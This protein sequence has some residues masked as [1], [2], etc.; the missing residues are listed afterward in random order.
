MHA[1]P[2]S[3][4]QSIVAWQA[5]HGRHDLPW[6]GTRDPYRIWLSEIMLQQTQVAAVI[7]YYQRFL[8]R[9]PSVAHLA[10]GTQE[11][12]LALWSGLGYYTRAR[13]LHACAIQVLEN[14]NGQFP[15]DPA[16]LETLPGIGRSTAAAIAAF[17][18]DHSSPIL[19]G[20]VKRVFCRVFAI[21]GVPSQPAV[22]KVLWGLAQRETPSSEHIVAY[23]QGVMDLGAT[24]CTRSRPRCLEC[25]LQSRCLAFSRGLQSSLPTPKPK[26]M[27]PERRLKWLVIQREGAVLLRKRGPGAVWEGLW[28]FP[29]FAQELDLPVPTQTLPIIEHQFSH[30]RLVATPC[31]AQLDGPVAVQEEQVGASQDPAQWIWLE[32]GDWAEAALPAP[33]KK[34]LLTRKT[35]EN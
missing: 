35:G 16:L 10:Q 28:A 4:A 20:N 15:R 24:L 18:F 5:V 32:Q 31:L 19:D 14:F 6:Q 29:E 23:T 2:D 33:I 1:H 11:E 3:L 30:Y 9:F 8:A 25:P 22:E 26:K 34:F 27:L 21:E 12:V 17:A 13:N 7:G